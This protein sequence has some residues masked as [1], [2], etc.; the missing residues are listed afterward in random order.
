MAFSCTQTSVLDTIVVLVSEGSFA[1][2]VE[3]DTLSHILVAQQFYLNQLNHPWHAPCA[4]RDS[5]HIAMF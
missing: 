5:A 2:K 4:G 3:F 1:H